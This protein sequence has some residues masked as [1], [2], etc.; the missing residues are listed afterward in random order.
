MA[1]KIKSK[2]AESEDW[3]WKKFKIEPYNK[4]PKSDLALMWKI[5]KEQGD[6]KESEK[7]IKIY[8]KRFVK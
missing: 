7:I 1:Y 4:M 8:K 5:S 6:T 2:K 3:S